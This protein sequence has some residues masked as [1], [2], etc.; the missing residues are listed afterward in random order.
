[1]EYMI[2]TV[3]YFIRTWGAMN[4]NMAKVCRESIP[5]LE[6]KYAM[7]KRATI[8]YITVSGKYNINLANLEH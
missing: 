7:H 2:M 3:K 1:M 8:M 4:S 5:L 6:A